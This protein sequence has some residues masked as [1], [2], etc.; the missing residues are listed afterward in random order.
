MGSRL[1]IGKL[2]AGSRTNTMCVAGFS[3]I[4]ASSWVGG[5]KMMKGRSDGGRDVLELLEDG[6]EAC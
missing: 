4:A 2:L 3:G 1:K 6:G 5:A